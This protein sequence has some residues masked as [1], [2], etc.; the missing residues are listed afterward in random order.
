[1]E[2]QFQLLTTALDYSNL[3]SA[4]QAIGTMFQV[5]GFFVS[6]IF[7]ILALPAVC[8]IG[9]GAAAGHAVATSAIFGATGS[10]ARTGAQGLRGAFSGARTPRFGSNSIG[11]G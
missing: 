8:A 11:R 1:M 2:G 5:V 10:M 6:D 7:W 4:D 9:S 3:S